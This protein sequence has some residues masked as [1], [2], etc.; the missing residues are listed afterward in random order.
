MEYWS[1]GSSDQKFWLTVRFYY[2][3]YSIF[4]SFHYSIGS[5][6][7]KK[8]P[9]PNR[10]QDLLLFIHDKPG[11]KPAFLWGFSVRR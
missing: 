4:P 1:N 10:E 6:P 8:I 3:H 7:A 11:R 2:A 5:Q 9:G